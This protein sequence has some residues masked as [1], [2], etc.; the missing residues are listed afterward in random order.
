[1]EIVYDDEELKY[2]MATAVKEISHDSPIL[3]DRY[4]LGKE[5]EIDA[6]ADGKEVLIPGLMEHIERAGIH[7]GDSISV[8][9]AENITQSV[10]DTIIDYA[11]RIGKG[12]GFIGLYN[13]QFIVDR[14]NRVYVLEVNPRS[15]RTVPFLSKITGVPMC[16]VATRCILQQCITDQGYEPGYRKEMENRVYVKAPVF[17]FA[18]LRSVDTVLGPEMKSTGEALGADCS[19][20]K[21][22][23]KALIASGVRIPKYGSVLLTIA[24][25][26]KADA[27]EL[28]KRFSRIGYGT[29]ATAGTAKYFEDN[30]LYVH[31]VSKISENDENNV[32]SL[33]QSGKVS[34]V[35]NTVDHHDKRTNLDG[36]LIRRVSAEN[37][38]SCMTSLDTAEALIKVLE[39]MSFQVVSMNEERYS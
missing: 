11:I 10:K 38:I 4:V 22:L 3:I 2:Y 39:S 24:D 30:G 20:E 23:Y 18:K 6:V 35:I 21:A 5:L 9:P 16:Q 33:I 34:F 27:L 26:D 29:Y 28:A 12:F 1:M 14:N 15:S 19:L 25:E 37:T 17:S 36:F 31:T 8:Y 32:L 13:I 7:S